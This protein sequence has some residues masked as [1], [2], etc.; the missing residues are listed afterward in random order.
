MRVRVAGL[1]GRQGVAQVLAFRS[2]GA[3]SGALAP[4]S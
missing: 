3:S 4:T 2:Q 1:G